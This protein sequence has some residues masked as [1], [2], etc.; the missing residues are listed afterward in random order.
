MIIYKYKVYKYI[1]VSAGKDE[2]PPPAIHDM[3]SLLFCD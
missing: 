1:N 2:P 3:L